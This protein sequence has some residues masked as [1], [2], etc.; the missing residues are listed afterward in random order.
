MSNPARKSAA[1]GG[2]TGTARAGGM[3]G[4]E[5]IGEERTDGKIDH[6]RNGAERKPAGDRITCGQRIARNTLTIAI[7]FPCHLST[8]SLHARCLNALRCLNDFNQ[9]QK[10]MLNLRKLFT[11]RKW[12][13][14]VRGD[15]YI[16]GLKTERM[17]SRSRDIGEKRCMG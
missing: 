11:G 7:A 14:V 5:R 13:R 16:W 12:Y 1:K 6:K 8:L 2:E 4:K 17:D 15:V 9:P 3:T 10:R